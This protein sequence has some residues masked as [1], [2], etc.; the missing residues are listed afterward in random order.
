MA[1]KWV[2]WAS[3]HTYN[4][5][6]AWADAV[7]RRYPSVN[8]VGNSGSGSNIANDNDDDDN[9]HQ[10]NRQ[11]ERPTFSPGSSTSYTNDTSL[12]DDDDSDYSDSGT[13]RRKQGQPRTALRRTP[14]TPPPIAAVHARQRTDPLSSIGGPVLA[15]IPLPVRTTPTLPS[16]D[17]YEVLKRATE[18]LP[19]E[20]SVKIWGDEVL[21]R[22]LLGDRGRKSH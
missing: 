4:I 6:R 14:T 20:V 9:L 12:N 18:R 15:P 19:R 21:L 7:D 10:E 3:K 16:Y 22:A 1:N 2:V 17:K 5:V 8:R 13:P 11:S